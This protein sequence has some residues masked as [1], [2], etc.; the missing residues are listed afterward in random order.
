MGMTWDGLPISADPPH[1]CAIVVFQRVG[2]GLRLL[3]LHRK[4]NGSAY[5][6]DWAWTSPSGARL[7][8][9][10]VIACAQRELAEEAGL[11]LQLHPTDCGAPDWFIYWAEAPHDATV[12]LLDAEHDRYEW[13]T[14]GE[15]LRRIAP[16]R[17]RHD[18][19]RVI[20]LLEELRQPGEE[21]AG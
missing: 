20:A 6:G 9:E 15:A 12:T 18:L 11:T 3:L 17:V 16:D 2:S 10:P 4:H 7:P 5:E 13:L 19:A 8:G 14:P 1:G 21:A